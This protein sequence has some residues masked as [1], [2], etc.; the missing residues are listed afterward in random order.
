MWAQTYNSGSR[1]YRE[2]RESR[3]LANCPSAGG[4]IPCERAD[5]QIGKIVEAI[6][7]G[8]KGEE[9]VLSVI[10]VGDEVERVKGRRKKVQEKLKRLGRAYVDGVYDDIEYR[11]Q[12]Q[13]LDAELESL[14]VPE[15]DAATE[16]GKLIEK[17]P[18]LWAWASVEDRR[19]LLV[20]MLDAVYVDAKEE[21]RSLRSSRGHRSSQS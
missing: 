4:S 6:E 13:L 11:R 15:A 1:L 20:T 19:R 9:E 3:S 18:E 17:L 10:S 14:V 5:E 2:H 7:L 8:P 16:A 21:G 12:K